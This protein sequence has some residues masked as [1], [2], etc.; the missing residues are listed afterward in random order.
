M[1][2]S[3]AGIGNMCADIVDPDDDLLLEL[4]ESGDLGEAGISESAGFLE[5]NCLSGLYGS[6]STALLLGDT[7][8]LGGLDIVSS[9]NAVGVVPKDGRSTALVLNRGLGFST[10]LLLGD[11]GELGGLVSRL[12]A[13]GA[14]SNV[15]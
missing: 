9:L 6:S 14:V 15:S 13:G 4:R 3:N 7:G 8:A 10:A 11:I 12:N 2:A 1:I 5:M